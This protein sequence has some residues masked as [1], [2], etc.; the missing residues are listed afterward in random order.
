MY[1]FRQKIHKNR[2]TLNKHLRCFFLLYQYKSENPKKRNYASMNTAARGILTILPKQFFL[3]HDQVPVAAW[4]SPPSRC[5]WF[6]YTGITKNINRHR[7]MTHWCK[8][9]H[10]LY[11]LLRT[12]GFRPLLPPM[13]SWWLKLQNTQKLPI[14]WTQ[15]RQM[16]WWRLKPLLKS[17]NSIIWTRTAGGTEYFVLFIF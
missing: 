3:N 15:S 10:R 1:Y 11:V 7:I 2:H 12:V 14:K 13:L 9:C 6:G 8:K 17:E 4:R 16:S 5:R